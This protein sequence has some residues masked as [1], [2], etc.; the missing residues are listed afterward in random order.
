[1]SLRII[2]G[3]KRGARLSAPE[4][5]ETRPLRDRVREAVFSSIRPYLRQSS[6]IDFFAGS[7]AVGLEALSNGAEFCIFVDPSAKA[8]QAIESNI[9]KLGYEEKALV[10]KG[11]SPDILANSKLPSR[12]FN[13]LFMMPPYHSGLCDSCFKHTSLE[14]IVGEG[15]MAV[16]ETHVN[17]ARPESL[18]WELFKDKTYGVTRISYLRY[19]DV[20]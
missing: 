2:S 19:I 15:S 5:L 20:H 10:I 18:K 13:L 11:S 8:I 17:E 6:V 9:Q 4:G 3:E 1:M 7:G 14:E 12:Q 16:C